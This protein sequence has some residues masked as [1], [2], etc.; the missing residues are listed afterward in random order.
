M[1]FP[2]FSNSEIWR[3]ISYFSARN[4]PLNVFMFL[5]S[6]FVPNSFWPAGRT[7]QFTSHRMFPCSRLQS[8]MSP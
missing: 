1:I 5:I 8:L 6:I 7:L 2:P 3:G 4:T